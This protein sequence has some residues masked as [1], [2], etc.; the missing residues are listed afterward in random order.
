LISS[1]HEVYNRFKSNEVTE[2]QLKILTSGLKLSATT[3]EFI[4]WLRK[5][6]RLSSFDEVVRCYSI[7][8][9]NQTGIIKA[10][11]V[12]G[13]S[14][15]A[16]EVKNL[17]NY[18]TIRHLQT[19]QKLQLNY[20]YDPSIGPG[21]KYDVGNVSV[22]DTLLTKLSTLH[23]SVNEQINQHFE[24]RTTEI[25]AIDFRLPPTEQELKIRALFDSGNVG[26][27]WSKPIDPTKIPDL[28]AQ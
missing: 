18:L 2:S 12:S 20:T 11:V 26:Y 10:N 22:D 17:E 23:E 8:R 21:L 9:D 14:L 19:G 3:G 25:N 15:D 13:D 6:R 7:L 16:A 27:D 24:A 1:R 28:R 5:Q 4:N